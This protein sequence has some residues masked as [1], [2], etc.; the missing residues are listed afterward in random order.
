MAPERF[1]DQSSPASDVYSFGV[2]LWQL[3]SEQRPFDGLEDYGAISKQVKKGDRPPLPE[4][5]P[6]KFE[7]LIKR[8]WAQQPSSRPS[9]QQILDENAWDAML[10]DAVMKGEKGSMEMWRKLGSEEEQ[11]T[12]KVPRMVPWKAFLNGFLSY[13]GLRASGKEIKG[14]LKYKCL[15]AV[16]EVNKGDEGVPKGSVALTKFERFLSWFGPVLP[17]AKEAENLFASIVSLLKQPWFH[18]AIDANEAAKRIELST[19]QNGFLLRFS[20]NKKCYTLTYRD[21]KE[22]KISHV[23]LPDSMTKDILNQVEKLQKRYKVT[24]VDQ[25][26]EFALL[27]TE[28]KFQ[29]SGY[30]QDDDAEQSDQTEDTETDDSEQFG[31]SSSAKLGQTTLK[32]TLVST[33]DDVEFIK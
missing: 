27:F 12:G 31:R 15:K 22:K 14:A 33:S 9:F 18:G 4:S 23:Q 13:L 3:L 30:F 17:N 6:E 7:A 29:L 24:P 2:I 20:A 10:L 26:R 16:L 32:M 8:C 25:N 5:A 19:I 21:V 1:D 28:K 11:K